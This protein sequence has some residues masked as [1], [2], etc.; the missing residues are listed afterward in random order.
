MASIKELSNHIISV[1]KQNDLTVTNLQLQKVLFFSIGMY[2]RLNG[3]VDNLVQRT[4]DIP[5]EKW[6][7][8][9]IIESL[10][11]KYNTFHKEDITKH[12][13]GQYSQEYAD[14]DNIIISLLNQDVFKLVRVSHDMPSWKDYEQQIIE[15][16]PVSSYTLEEIERDFTR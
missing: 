4:Y 2:I 6:K 11:Y 12:I 5:F 9:P 13:D 16:I 8:G 1:G 3:G 10:Y 14:W 7:Y 15:M